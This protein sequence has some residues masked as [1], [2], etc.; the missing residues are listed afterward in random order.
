MAKKHEAADGGR[1]FSFRAG[2]CGKF[3]SK[4]LSH[5]DHT[6]FGVSVLLI[7]FRQFLDPLLLLQVTVEMPFRMRN[8]CM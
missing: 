4:R 6:Q 8:L 7:V 1:I 5:F 3:T 2:V